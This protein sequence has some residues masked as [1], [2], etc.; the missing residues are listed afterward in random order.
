M[1][2]I[3]QAINDIEEFNQ[4]CDNV[5]G[6]TSPESLIQLEKEFKLL[7]EKY[8]KRF[9]EEAGNHPYGDE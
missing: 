7:Q 1:S 9:V 6:N 8:G 4:R 5:D 3:K 2:K